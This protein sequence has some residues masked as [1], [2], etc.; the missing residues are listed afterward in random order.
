MFYVPCS[1]L[2]NC[3]ILNVS[4]LECKNNKEWGDIQKHVQNQNVYVLRINEKKMKS[5]CIDLN[6]NKSVTMS[7]VY[8]NS[9]TSA[10]VGCI[11]NIEHMGTRRG[12]GK[13]R[14]SP[15]PLENP[16]PPPKK[17]LKIKKN[18]NLQK[19]PIVCYA[20][21]FYHKR[22]PCCVLNFHLK[23]PPC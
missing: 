6:Y 8:T 11:K 4:L 18:F 17:R 3:E 20:R 21:K 10:S 14:P 2:I 23:R 22:P 12:G 5:D 7:H 15:H 9:V 16:T 19:A 13:S 1:I